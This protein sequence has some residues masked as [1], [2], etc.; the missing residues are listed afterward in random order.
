[1][2]KVETAIVR[3]TALV[4]PVVLLEHEFVMYGAACS[5]LVASQNRD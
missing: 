3:I 1:M 5:A 2:M 4:I